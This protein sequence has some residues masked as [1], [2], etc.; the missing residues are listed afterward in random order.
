M[1]VYEYTGVNRTGKK[2]KGLFDAENPRT[3]RDA[4]KAQNIYV[5]EF[6]E[7][8]KVLEKKK[9]DIEMPWENR[10]SLRDVAI[11]TRQLAT[12]QRAGIPL[13]TCLTALVEQTEHEALKAVL[14]DVRQKVNEGSSLNAALADHP[15]AFSDLYVNMIRA[16]ESTGALDTVLYRL[17]DFLDTQVGLRS[18]ISGAL[19]YPILM[20]ILSAGI[21]AFLM[22]FV[23]PR[24]TQIYADQEQGL[25]LIT[26]ILITVS[27]F[28]ASWWFPVFLAACGFA[29]YSFLKWKKTEDGR[30]RWDEFV[31]RSPVFGK[32]TRLIAMTRFSRTLATLLGAGV[33]LL[34]ALDIIKNI[35]GNTVLIKVVEQA[36]LNIREGESI[37]VPLKRSGEFPPMVTH[38][39]AVGEQT[40]ALE[41]M[42]HNVAD[43]YDQQVD[44]KITSLT[45]L[46]EPVMIVVM[47]GGVAFIVFAILIP[48]LRMNSAAMG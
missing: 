1:P 23:V 12:Q 22:G 10:I 29:F 34:K 28:I 18:K 11:L 3:L 13:A 42:L 38:M 8:K 47:G 24:I 5:T 20:S 35:L 33:P 39:I 9:G 4:L 48:I 26:R 37:A 19:A 45:S 17:A 2:V 25:P 16:G 21:M 6:V 31:L 30:A 27:N 46:L 41:E 32:L 7:G 43:S 36:R 14:S 15:K 44:A 40:G